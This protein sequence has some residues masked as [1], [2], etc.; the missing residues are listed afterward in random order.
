MCE[1]FS[2]A[3][4]SWGNRET[5]T[6]KVGRTHAHPHIGSFRGKIQDG[7]CVES[8]AIRVGIESVHGA[9]GNHTPRLTTFVRGRLKGDELPFAFLPQTRFGGGSKEQ[10]VI[11]TDIA[12]G[13]DI[14]RTVSRR[15]DAGY[16]GGTEQVP[17]FVIGKVTNGIR[18]PGHIRECHVSRLF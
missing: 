10:P 1:S 4:M 8:S 13:K 7:E 9:Q 18:N 16:L 11:V 2:C 17:G 15:S 14:G 5:A 3:R 12:D 6:A